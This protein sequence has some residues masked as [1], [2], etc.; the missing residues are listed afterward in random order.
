MRLQPRPVRSPSFGDHVPRRDRPCAAGNGVPPL[1]A[2]KV[3]PVPATVRPVVRAGTYPGPD[4]V[5]HPHPYR[6]G[7]GMHRYI[8]GPPL[9]G[10]RDSHPCGCYW[11]HTPSWRW[12]PASARGPQPGTAPWAP[13]ACTPSWHAPALRRR[14]TWATGSAS[15]LKPGGAD[16]FRPSVSG[17]PRALTAAPGA[18]IPHL[19][20]WARAEPHGAAWP[21]RVLPPRGSAHGLAPWPR[22]QL[23][24]EHQPGARQGGIAHPRHGPEAVP[25]PER[26]RARI[27]ESQGHGPGRDRPV[28]P[29]QLLSY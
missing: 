17:P 20:S 14:F 8:P 21:A 22:H 16:P 6:G 23:G 26:L 1:P 29:P 13:V 24:L 18:A 5:L 3:D 28:P 19:N 12:G 2:V 15:G 27:G 4:K 11:F 7:A 25:P 10:G 9:P